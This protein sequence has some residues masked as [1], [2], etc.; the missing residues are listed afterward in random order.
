[1]FHKLKLGIYS[2]MALALVC[3]SHNAFASSKNSPPLRIVSLSPATTEW[4]DAF[5]MVDSLVGVTEQCDFPPQVKSVA[6]V[7]SF[8][9]TSLER[10]LLSKPTDVVTVAGLPSI[11]RQQL[12]ASGVRVHVFEIHQLADF[13]TQIVGLGKV[14]DATDR[15]K[16]W[17]ESFRTEILEFKV[18]ERPTTDKSKTLSA[19]PGKSVL[20]LVS[21]QP[22]Y[23]ATP[24]SWLSELFEKAGFRNGMRDSASSFKGANDFAQISLESLLK[25]RSDLWVTFSDQSS[26]DEGLRQ[27]ARVMFKRGKLEKP[28]RVEV[29]SAD[30]FNRPGPRLLEAF[31]RLKELPR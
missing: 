25:S 17:A 16:V 12:M 3:W 24:A 18:G 28:P 6:K 27:R 2:L 30:L 11:L 13:P 20:L 4:V 15:A 10:V 7:G 8:M 19:A 9:R 1:M 29:L 23:V 22:P 5:G 31:R 14:L 26:A 21:L